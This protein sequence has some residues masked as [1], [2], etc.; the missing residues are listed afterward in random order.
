MHEGLYVRLATGPSYT[1]DKYK[2]TYNYILGS[3]V[4][5]EGTVDGFGAGF[6]AGVGG[7][8]FG[9][10][11]VGG[12]IFMDSAFTTRVKNTGQNP[13][14]PKPYNMVTV[15][16]ML[17]FYPDAKGGLHFEIGVG[18]SGGSGVFP[19]QKSTLLD[20]GLAGGAGYEWWV[21]EVW[22]LGVM[23]RVHHSTGGT[24]DS[25]GGIAIVGTF[26]DHS[27]TAY[28]LLLTATYD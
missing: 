15:G 24:N 11:V 9:H 20:W 6:E 21:S 16:P 28:A 3:D 25:G 10:L 26:E 2:A 13:N 22:S 8:I 1:H 23:A 27:R 17:D 18:F 5:G 19:H 4:V 14:P 7:M 12:A